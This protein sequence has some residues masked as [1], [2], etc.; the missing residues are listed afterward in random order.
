MMMVISIRVQ[1]G[2]FIYGLAIGR[3]IQ[4]D[5]DE[6]RELKLPK[7]RF[8]LMQIVVVLFAIYLSIDLINQSSSAMVAVW[9]MTH[10]AAFA[11]GWPVGRYTVR[12][13]F[14]AML[15]G[16]TPETLWDEDMLREV[17]KLQ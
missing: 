15:D 4:N 2:K 17:E 8:F 9:S 14:H 3:R 11:L 16:K 7:M 1:F 5:M 13:E 12:M 10:I 6:L